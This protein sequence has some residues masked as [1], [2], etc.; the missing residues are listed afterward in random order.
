MGLCLLAASPAGAQFLDLDKAAARVQREID[1]R[2]L[3][4]KEVLEEGRM[5]YVIRV[6]TPDGRVVHVRVDQETGQILKAPARKR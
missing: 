6:L 1:G 4:G 5:V 3:G 2:V